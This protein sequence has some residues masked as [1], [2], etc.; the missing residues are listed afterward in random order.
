MSVSDAERVA[1]I[2]AALWH[3]TLERAEQLLAA[4]PDLASRDLHTAAIV[5][6]DALVRRLLAADPSLVSSRSPPWG[7]DPLN[8]LCLS[9]YLRLDPR[10]S[11]SFVRAATALLD[12]GADPNTGFW[13]GGPFPERETALYGAA[14]V[15]HHAGLTRLLLER[16]ADPNDPEVCYH[17]PE[18]YDLEAMRLVVETGRVTAAN[19]TLMLV[20]KHDWHDHAG[21]KFL[22]EHGADPNGE[23]SRRWMPLHHALMRDN[24]L[25]TIELL[26]EHGAKPTL[27]SRGRTAV[28]LAA[29]R[30]RGDVLDRFAA[31]GCEAGLTGLD[32]LIAACAR[33]DAAAASTIARREAGIED[34]LLAAGGE[35]LAV[36][37]GAG[38]VPGVELLL[39]LGVPPEARWAEGDGYWDIPP[40]STALHVAAWRARHGVVKLLIAR[41]APVDVADANGRTPLALAVRAC[42]DSWWQENRR[43][44]SVAVLLAAGASA[45]EAAW[46]TGYRAIDDLVAR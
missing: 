28:A 29:W 10:R 39:D 5:G 23:R 12:A 20:R 37:A 45:G 19:L 41:G 18:S 36:F 40:G 34:R 32:A 33:G 38:N 43:P 4:R 6:D 15:A 21:V 16:G 26:L 9:K 30:G 44:D 25:P 3:G 42:V 1:F 27:E 2:E 31:R 13:T 22:L 8:Y 14:G 35:L 11:D 17:S 24:A 7:G 46:P